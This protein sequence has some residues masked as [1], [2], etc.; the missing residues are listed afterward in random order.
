MQCSSLA[1]T[2]L[3]VLRIA[4][5]TTDYIC[6]DLALKLR[7]EKRDRFLVS[8]SIKTKNYPCKWHIDLY[9]SF[10]PRRRHPLVVEQRLV[11]DG[12]VPVQGDAAEVEDGGSAEG[13]VHRVVGLQMIRITSSL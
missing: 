8:P 7:Q 6:R 2:V 10:L 11:D 12:E 1:R 13:H 4:Q 3:S 9:C 5:C